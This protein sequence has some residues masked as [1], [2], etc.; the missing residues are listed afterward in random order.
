MIVASLRSGAP[1]CHMRA[2]EHARRWARAPHREP[3]LA[4]LCLIETLSAD[5]VVLRER[6]RIVRAFSPVVNEQLAMAPLKVPR[7][8][9]VGSGGLKDKGDLTHFDTASVREFGRRYG[10][11]FLL[12]DP[13]WGK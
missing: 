13:G 8:M 7:C 1:M 3:V 12:L 6:Q 2:Q 5:R 10:L 9:F 11:A 4:R